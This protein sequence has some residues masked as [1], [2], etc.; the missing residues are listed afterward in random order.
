MSSCCESKGEKSF[1]AKNLNEAIDLVCGMTVDPNDCAASTEYKEKT[2][3]FCSKN[4]LL[5]F[6]KTPEDFLSEELKA[7][8]V[9]G[10]SKDALYTCPMHSAIKQVGPGSC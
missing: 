2:Y 8:K 1:K 3:F 10:V 6:K 4:C 9:S 7:K 5:S